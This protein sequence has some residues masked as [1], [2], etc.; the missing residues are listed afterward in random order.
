MIAQRYTWSPNDFGQARVAALA[1]LAGLAEKQGTSQADVVLARYHGLAEKRPL[2]MQAL[3]DWLYLCS[4]RL[5]YPGAYA[6]ARD[7]AA[8]RRPTRS[9]SGRSCTAWEAG[10]PPRG[11]EL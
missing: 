4:V 3:R 11:S 10:R 1:W 6:A 9:R 7:L 5:D 8:R 2:D